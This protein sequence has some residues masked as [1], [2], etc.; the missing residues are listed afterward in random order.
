MAISVNTSR[1][2]RWTGTP[3]NNVD[4][5]SAAATPANA[6][7]LVLCIN[8]D[9]QGSN[10]GALTFTVAGGSLTWT[11]R[12]HRDGSNTINCGVVAIYTAPVV[13]GTSM[14]I[15]VRRTTT[16]GGGN[17]IS[18]KVYEVTGHNVVSS[19]GNSTTNTSTTNSINA[20]LTVAGAGRLFGVA[21]DWNQLGSPVSSDTEDPADYGGEISVLSAFKAADHVSGSQTINFDAAGASAPAWNYALLEIVAD[22]GGSISGTAAITL[23]ALTVS[24]ASA[25]AIA[26]TSAITL[27][28]VTLSSAG[29]VA[30]TGAFAKTLADLTLSSS[31]GLLIVGSLAKTLGD[32]T[33][34]ATSTI[35]DADT[36]T[37]SFS[38][39][40]DALTLSGTSLIPITG[41]F[42][43]TLGALVGS[44]AGSLALNGQAAIILAPLSLASA[45]TL[46]IKGQSAFTLGALTLDAF[47]LN[48]DAV[49]TVS[50]IGSRRFYGYVRRGR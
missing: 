22:A 32:L 36:I 30:L 11:E 7:L 35:A 18:C 49:V 42:N 27:G 34:S 26:G 2:A 1:W 16:N 12:A 33:L 50:V 48:P 24:S 37:G 10:S 19:I 14:T 46:L 5:T 9:Q 23:G 47:G 25:L 29:Q 21:T 20:A 43:Q 4:I 39:T 38:I 31:G 6:S 13:V 41:A 44:G 17:R 40:L 45:S 28:A 3:A 8:A 15:A